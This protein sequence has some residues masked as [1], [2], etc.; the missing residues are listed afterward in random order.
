[1]ADFV[2]EA[3]TLVSAPTFTFAFLYVAIV[4]GRRALLALRAGAGAT[5]LER[6][7]VSAAIG[8]GLLRR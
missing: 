1:M 3:P 6:G 7:V 4:V 5:T 8:L 2:S